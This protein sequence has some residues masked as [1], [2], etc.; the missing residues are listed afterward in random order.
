MRTSVSPLRWQIFKLA[1]R[2]AYPR[3]DAVVCVSEGIAQGLC[4]ALPQL[5]PKLHVIG[6][7]V[8]TDD[9][10]RQS[11]AP[12]NHPWAQPGQPPLVLAV[13]RL[14]PAKGFDVLLTAFKQV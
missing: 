4:K 3:A 10:L 5:Q 1:L 9:M 6:N 2:W 7:P 12:L 11:H 8:V 14:I 13:G